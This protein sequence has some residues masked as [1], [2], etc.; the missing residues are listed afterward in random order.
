[1]AIGIVLAGGN[2]SRM[3]SSVAKQYMLIN[4]KEVIAYA[5]DTFQKNE[6][7]TDIVLV[8]R[9]EDLEFCRNEII[10]KY[11][12]DKVRRLVS[13]GAERYASVYQGL[14]AAGD[15]FRADANISYSGN[16]KA[17]HLEERNQTCVCGD[18]I[19]VIH[20]GARPFVTNE[21]INSSI[22]CAAK[23]RACTVGVPVKDT[24]KIVD[25]NMNGVKTPDRKFLYQIQTPQAF[26]Y[27]LIMEAYEK[28]YLE[29]NAAHTGE[30]MTITDD[31]MLVELYTGIKS[32]VI[33]GGYEN[34]KITTP[35][36]INIAEIFSENFL[37][38]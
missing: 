17:D 34:I 11:C 24:I 15:I 9:N 26:D 13:G 3:N 27:K 2:G 18:E 35:E 19:V 33:F 14:L 37:K 5:L 28:M 16:Y 32:K 6:H 36:D 4:G 10:N 20:D 30:K 25:E 23:T 38:N 31:T 12:F 29:Q 22:A 1:M 7:I 8:A 21:M